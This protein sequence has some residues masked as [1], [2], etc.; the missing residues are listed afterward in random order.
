[1]IL[2]K[3][4]RILDAI[5]KVEKY[6]LGLL[7][8]MMTLVIFLQIILRTFS[9]GNLTW[10]EEVCCIII[11]ESAFIAA[12]I[13][14]SERGHLSLNF[15]RDRLKGKAKAA[16]E[17]VIDLICTAV[18]IWTC[19]AAYRLV[20]MMLP[21]KMQFGT[22]PFPRWVIYVPITIAM[23]TMAIR[24]LINAIEDF[25]VCGGK[26]VPEEASGEGDEKE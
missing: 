24:F 21:L 13:A 25:A 1:M 12:C 10:L 26:L 6:I 18:C 9:L 16:A 14:T 3:I 11:I 22:L 2:N 20:M 5:G 4:K 15:I 17:G 23:G 8:L 7:F 19:C